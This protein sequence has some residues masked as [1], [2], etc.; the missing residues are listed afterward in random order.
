MKNTQTTA[1]E[2]KKYI[3]RACGLIYDEALGDPDS[4]LVAGT[5]LRIFLMTGSALY[6]V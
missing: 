4:G 6:A 2:W 5:R 1:I 3:C